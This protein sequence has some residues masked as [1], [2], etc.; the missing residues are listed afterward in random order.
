[1]KRE[2]VS[3]L[4]QVRSFIVLMAFVVAACIAIIASWP[5]DQVLFMNAATVS[6]NLAVSVSMALLLG[7]ALFIPA[8]A[9]NSISIER[10]QETY[11]LLHCSLI[12]ASVMLLAKL[13][14]TL[15][16]FVLLLVAVVPVVSSAF[17]LVGLETTTVLRL[18][19]L[20]IATATTCA[21]IGMLAS[22]YSRKTIKAIAVSYVGMVM[23][24]GL[25]PLALFFSWTLVAAFFLDIRSIGQS[26]EVFYYIGSPI[27]TMNAIANDMLLTN[28]QFAMA[29]GW[30]GFLSAIC[31]IWATMALRRPLSVA[32]TNT[33]KIIDNTAVL[34]ARRTS[35][36]FYLI[37]PLRRKKTIEDNR[38]PMM[39]RELR[40]GLM[41]RSTILI[42]V[43]YVSFLFYFLLGAMSVFG[44]NWR[45]EDIYGWIFV[46][47]AVTI[48]VA[49]ALVAN[50]LTKEHELG[51][52]DML[53]MTLLRPRDIV[54]GKILAGA[55]SV[56]PLLMAVVFASIPAVLI[57]GAKWQLLVTGYGSLIV[58]T[59][60][61][62]AIGLSASLISKRTTVSLVLSY[63]C[64]VTFFVALPVL[65]RGTLRNI[66]WGTNERNF[67]QSAA[68][69]IS[70]L[71]AFESN[72]KAEQ[73]RRQFARDGYA[74]PSFLGINES[75]SYISLYWYA[76][77]AVFTL[78][79]FA[80]I[81]AVIR[82]FERYR[83]QDR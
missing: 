24:M 74:D 76:N 46:Q 25:G 68:G 1:M 72:A 71:S 34:A 56:S 51:N 83:M 82:G 41:S 53:R 52:M 2:L 27:G 64:G 40:W 45:D 4:R 31:L 49:P 5:D 18:A 19:L 65:A 39:V 23:A 62:L 42:R 15:G 48:L 8:F 17:F 21:S 50:S 37:D 80:L 38:N 29:L 63:M 66:L 28:G 78:L 7:C 75:A 12:P 30:Q 6:E 36:P 3:T 35:F 32:P 73:I 77:I 14:N 67:I 79:S 47:I 43:F 54:L 20:I 44:T 60:M 33:D 61:S 59:M 81:Y 22:A 13:M 55:L 69:F 11:D 9:A 26:M 10:E 57:A 16:F 70:P 58:C